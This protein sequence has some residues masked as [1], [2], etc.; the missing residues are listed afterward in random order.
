MSLP[1]ALLSAAAGVIARRTP[2]R[3]NL[4]AEPLILIVEHRD[5]LF[6]NVA[7]A[8]TA[9][10]V[11]IARAASAAEA[12]ERLQST[13][14]DLT[15]ANCDQPDE[16]AWLMVS[17]WCLTRASKRVWLYQAWPAPFDQDWVDF[18]NVERL[19]YYRDDGRVLANEVLCRLW[20]GS[21]P[22][23]GKRVMQRSTHK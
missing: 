19:L 21:P 18:T 23:P 3:G 17:K 12:T 4:P 6:A 1:Q 14:P 7:T 9:K 5:E 11:Q 20:P 10:G 22:K 13:S 8:L 16:S 2:D 15:L